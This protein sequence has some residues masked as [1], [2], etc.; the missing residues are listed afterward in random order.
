MVLDKAPV[1]AAFLTVHSRN[2][3]VT[4]AY[5]AFFSRIKYM[6]I[7]VTFSPLLYSYDIH[8]LATVEVVELWTVFHEHY[9]LLNQTRNMGH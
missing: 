7:I 6:E 5:E 1:L 4:D 9:S 2:Q 3:E 8:I